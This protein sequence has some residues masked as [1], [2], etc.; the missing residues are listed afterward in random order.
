MVDLPAVGC[1]LL[2]QLHVLL[3][4]LGLI[5]GRGGGLLA[6]CRIVVRVRVAS[7]VSRQ[8]VLL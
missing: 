7:P 1:S 5:G 4:L 2:L 6:L 8:T 3:M